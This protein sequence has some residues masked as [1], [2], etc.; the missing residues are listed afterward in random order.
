MRA[1]HCLVDVRHAILEERDR[2]AVFLRRRVADGIGQIDGGGAGLDRRLDTAAEIVKR[3]AG[4]VHGRP[5]DVLDQVACAGDSR[6]DDLEHL[7]LGLAHLVCEVDGRGRDER[8]NAPTL[9]VAHGITGATFTKTDGT[10]IGPRGGR[11]YTPQ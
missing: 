10:P 3:R 4:R 6:G 11:E 2:R 1:D 7:G 9:R 8:M 5:F